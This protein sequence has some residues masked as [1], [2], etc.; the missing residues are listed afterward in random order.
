[1]NESPQ[2]FESFWEASSLDHF[3]LAEFAQA[4]SAF[5]A[6]VK[7]LR[8]EFPG[9]AMPLPGR[10]V[11]GT[12]VVASALTRL[13]SRRASSRSFSRRTLSRG[14]ASTVLAG[15]YAHRGLE[16]RGFPSAGATYVTEAFVVG[17]DT[18]GLTG[19]IAYYD[20]ESH[21]LVTVSRD[22]PAW[23][24]ARAWLNVSVEA[25]PGLLVVL[26][27]FPQRVTAKYGDRG[28]R[29]A[30]LEAG[31]AM[32]QLSLAVAG[33]RRLKGVIVGGMLD[34]TWLRVLRLSHTDARV[35]V[36][37]LVGR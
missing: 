4:M 16:H 8:L 9:K 27:A 12:R 6:D 30:L 20:A 2:A 13:S 22:A 36:G 24:D 11:R 14:D 35:V 28:G 29:F 15:L 23:T 5:D 17:F 34:K 33:S 31:A 37:Y 25:V 21:G 1:M 19:E 10:P 26:V 32:Q 18:Q 7:E 3:N